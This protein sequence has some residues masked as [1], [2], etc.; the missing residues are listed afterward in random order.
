MTQPQSLVLRSQAPARIALALVALAGAPLLAADLPAGHWEGAIE[1][2]GQKLDFDVD[3][4]MDD[5][6]WAGDISIPAQGAKDLPLEE[7]AVDGAGV[8]FAITGV[9]GSPTFSG[10][11]EGSE[12]AGDFTQGGATF[13]FRMWTGEPLAERARAALVG[14]DPIL[15][16]ALADFGVP[17]LALAVVADGEV[18]FERGWGL[19]D[20]AGKKPVTPDTL[21]AIG[22]TTKAFTAFVL[23]TLVEEGKLEWDEPVLTYLSDFRLHDDHSTR[24]LK[25]RDLLI[26]ASGLPRHDLVWYNSKATREELFA[27]LRH[28][29]PTRDLGEEFQY[30]NLMYLTAG[31]LAERV[32]GKPW[33]ELVRERIFGPLG[34]TRSNFSVLA[35]QRDDDHALPYTIEDRVPRA[36]PFRDITTIGPAGSINSS[37]SEMTQWIRLQLG[38][39]EVDGK[40]LL[41]ATAIHEMHTPHN[42]IP[43]YP[44]DQDVLSI[45]YGL[46]W[47]LESHRG[48]FLV[49]HGGG[50]DGFISW[51]ALLP[52]DRIGVVAYTNASGLNPLPSVAARTVID[53]ILALEPIDYVAKAREQLAQAA[54]TEAEAEAN[55]TARRREGTSPSRELAS[56]AGEFEHPGYGVVRVDQAG[57]KLRAVYNDIP[58]NLEHWHH[59][60]WNGVVEEGE[61]PTFED[62]KVQFRLDLDGEVAELVAAFEPAVGPI[63]FERKAEARL[64]ETAYLE[65]F[66]GTYELSGQ[67]GTVALSGDRLRLALPS[68]PV[69]TLEPKRENEFAL[70]PLEGY[71]VEF[72]V[73]AAGAVTGARFHQPNGTFEAR[74]VDE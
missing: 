54:R 47:A 52:L 36:I 26:H 56:Y 30:Q 14:I 62:A 74:K 22:S 1:L 39:G 7:I 5:S 67:R 21:F 3:L 16:Q 60:T 65:R 59:D 46:G 72:L 29:E 48:H 64:F 42:A 33:E 18:V 68:Q 38:G 2:P 12:I 27:R 69:Y 37:V 40:R 66:A 11:L 73:D 13:P 53:R 44:D 6:A 35:S 4:R 43:Q 55:K 41:P 71:L 24:R 28:L 50:I 10:E 63:V 49:Q 20:V 32:T 23:A 17:G 8:R 19:R 25:V 57:G 9:P 45:G 34:M 61:D 58:V 15:E 31:Y 51:V 70:G